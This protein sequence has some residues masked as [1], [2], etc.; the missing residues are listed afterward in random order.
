MNVE[1]SVNGNTA[2]LSPLHSLGQG[3]FDWVGK[4]GV[5]LVALADAITVSLLGKAATTNV[6]TREQQA[7]QLFG[8]APE[9]GELPAHYSW[10]Q[11]Q[12]L[13]RPQSQHRD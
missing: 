8:L 5:T 2:G 11:L 7:M 4:L 1:K 3:W 9:E 6:K 13:S 10:E 12:A